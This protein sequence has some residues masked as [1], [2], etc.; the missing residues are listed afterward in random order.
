MT[1][2]NIQNESKSK[3][4]NTFKNKKIKERKGE[5]VSE[6]LPF[7][8]LNHRGAGLEFTDG[9][10]IDILRIR[11]K[12]LNAS[13]EDVIMGDIYKWQKF[14]KTYSNEIKLVGI[15]FPCNT[16]S[17]QMYFRD[18]IKR[19]KNR[20]QLDILT[21]KLLRLERLEKEETDREYYI[22]YYADDINALYESRS[23]ILSTLSDLVEDISA[24]KKVQLFE[25]IFNPN[26]LIIN[27]DNAVRYAIHPEGEA[28]IKK[29]GYDPYLISAIQ[30]VGGISF[31]DEK[32]ISTGD[33]YQ[34]VLYIY[35]YPDTG[36]NRHWLTYIMNIQ[37][38]V[39]TVDITTDNMEEVKRNIKWSSSE[40]ASRVNTAKNTADAIEAQ[41]KKDE[42]NELFIEVSNMGEVIKRIN[43][44]VF[45]SARTRQ[46]LSEIIDKIQKYLDNNDYK[47][48]VQIGET[49]H[50]WSSLFLSKSQQDKYTQFKQ[51]GQP[52]TSVTL[53]GGYPFHF[54]SLDVKYGS[55]I[56]MT[57]A[58]G[59]NGVV[60]FD[61]AEISSSRTH[62]NFAIVGNM[63]MGKSTLL[64]MLMRDRFGRNDYIRIIDKTGEYSELA[65]RMGG[66][67]ISLDGSGGIINLFQIN[68]AGE[69]NKISYAMNMSRLSTMYK[70]LAPESSH[71]EGLV[72][73]ELVDDMYKSF[74]IIPENIADI[75]NVKITDLPVEAYPICSDFVEIVRKRKDKETYAENLRYINNIERVF[76]NLI[77]TYG[78]LFNGHSSLRDI[79]NAQ[80][81]VYDI[82]GVAN[83]NSEI[84]DVQLFQALSLSWANAVKIGAKSKKDYEDGKIDFK[85]IQRFFLVID[86]AAYSINANKPYAVDALNVYARE[87]RKFFAGIGLATQSIRDYV[88]ETS[89]N[90]DIDKIKNLFDFS[91]Y[92]FIFK[93]D[94]N[95]V[96]LLNNVF[97]ASITESEIAAIPNLEKGECILSING[98]K[99]IKFHV[100]C[101]DEEL[102]MFKGGV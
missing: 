4:K 87:G 66:Y 22:F 31:K 9:T 58:N 2:R 63:G 76:N 6:I 81:I 99:N 64:K 65:K 57:V 50:E 54:T 75:E 70:F 90:S 24:S 33:G 47:C 21:E 26:T 74:Q 16:K 98:D 52:V 97:G 11:C 28:K 82:K 32:I 23:N 35:Q 60:R 56:G 49:Y 72:F 38:A 25:K 39:C 1:E 8:R 42:L 94:S 83:L 17:Q 10:Y 85:D 20:E 61:A 15:N 77:A 78:G 19:T 7:K 44:H 12:D 53:A 62:Y 73:Q 100:D 71:E 37:G 45:L 29:C 13:D 43:C 88:P 5:N 18:K 51:K 41:I 84:F 55:P 86:E 91:Q 93:Q 95:A 69:T 59:A 34:A 14:Y 40:Y 92:K 27:D 30:P 102:E 67:V 68:A 101:T 79:I 80:F 89:L 46:E 96:S 36:V 3:K 48:S